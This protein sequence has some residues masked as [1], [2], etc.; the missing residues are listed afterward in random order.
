MLSTV[1][2]VHKDFPSC[3]TGVNLPT[4]KSEKRQSEYCPGRS[5]VV[6]SWCAM[7]MA[8]V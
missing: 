8:L 5:V 7:L 2:V 6:E 4:Y 3:A 1:V